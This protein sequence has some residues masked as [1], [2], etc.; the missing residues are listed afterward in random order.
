M[1]KAQMHGESEHEG[2]VWGRGEHANMPKDVKMDMYPK[3]N[4]AGPM[5]EDDTMT[6]VDGENKRAKSSTRKYLSNQH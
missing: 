3:A 5:V 4:E 1:G 6:R 2:K